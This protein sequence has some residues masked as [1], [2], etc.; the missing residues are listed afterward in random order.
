MTQNTNGV[1]TVKT[2][3]LP[4]YNN[5]SH[6]TGDGNLHVPAT[7]TGNNGKFLKAGSTAGSISWSTIN[8]GDIAWAGGGNLK[9][10]ASAN[11]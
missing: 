8:I 5:Y 6:P 3:P 10:T 9:T 11:G 7:G 2:R 1:I 4:T